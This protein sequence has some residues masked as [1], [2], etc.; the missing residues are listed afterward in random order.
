MI[1]QKN[2]LVSA[3]CAY[4]CAVIFIAA[5]LLKSG[6]LFAF[7]LVLYVGI[8]GRLLKLERSQFSRVN[9]WVES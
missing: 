3:T 8:T 4:A 6:L 2:I 9:K 1:M 5:L 7:A